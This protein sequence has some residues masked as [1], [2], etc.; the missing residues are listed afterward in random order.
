[1]N[2][3]KRI[4]VSIMVSLMAI[5]SSNIVF[6][7][8]ESMSTESTITG[9]EKQQV[10]ESDATNIK[11]S[12]LSTTAVN[13]ANVGDE[14][15]LSTKIL[16]SNATVK[17]LVWSSSNP[18][19]ATVTQ[20]G[21]VTTVGK[22]S[23]KI[24][25][26]TTDGTNISAVASVLVKQ[27][28]SSILLSSKNFVMDMGATQ[29]LIP[30][31]LPPDATS[32]VL[33]WSSSNPNVASINSMGVITAKSAGSCTVL[34]KATDGTGRFATC[35]VTV[36]Q[37]AT[38]VSISDSFSTM[39]VGNTKTVSA[40]VSPANA[41]NKVVQWSSSNTAIATV[42]ARGVVTAKAPGTC[43]I[44]ATT[45]DGTNISSSFNVTVKGSDIPVKIISMLNKT[46][47][48]G[49]NTEI[50]IAVLP[51]NATRKDVTYTT[52]N[53]AVAKVSQSGIIT[54]VSK[55][56]CTIYATANDGS[57]IKGSCTV[58]VKRPV[59]NVTLNAHS[60]S[61]NVGRSAHFY[62]TVTPD[63][64]SNLSVKYTSSNPA[65]ATVDNTGLLTAVSA[66]SCTITCKASDGSG[67]YDTC[68]VV[69]KQPVTNITLNGD[70]TVNVDDKIS[71]VGTAF[72]TNATNR[73]LEWSS[74]DTS[75]AIVS[76]TGVVTGVSEGTAT[77]KCSAKDGSGAYTTK[78]IIVKNNIPS[79]NDMGQQIADYAAQWVGI[80]P[81]VWGGTSL[82]YGA[83]CS[84]FVCSVY[85]HFGYNLWYARIDLDTVGYEVPLSQA[86]PGDIVVYPGHVAIYAGNGMVTHALNEYYG[87][88]TTD[89]SWGGTV[90][91]VRRVVD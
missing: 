50:A 43:T 69:V 52:S 45:K 29:Q 77:I 54:A 28:V 12:S 53:S 72:P 19:V 11:V 7:D 58:T 37:P 47:N 46:L 32:K 16:P 33:Q 74:S 42:S 26:T 9:V 6:A 81:Y 21:V 64:A 89:I 15:E 5:G 67:A 13:Y 61:W 90:R 60:I 40:T 51:S 49:E 56:S 30:T 38:S 34:A 3:S 76:S 22:G 55:G 71:L 41:T 8:N 10:V 79:N 78:K 20:R 86:K 84:G 85:D 91:C 44:K 75:V 88:L 63:S 87:T 59:T 83:D 18:N 68:T 14:F 48:E 27:P 23:C 70:S 66:G 31:I 24:I 1:M 25:A 65:V 4:I 80:T 82:Y 17:T 35:T 57:G 39:E 73:T 36:I 2:L 62:P